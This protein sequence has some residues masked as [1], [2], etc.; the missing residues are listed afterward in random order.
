[1]NTKYDFS[2]RIQHFNGECE[3]IILVFPRLKLQTTVEF[4]QC[5]YFCF[6]VSCKF[7]MICEPNFNLPQTINIDALRKSEE[8]TNSYDQQT[9]KTVDAVKHKISYIQSQYKVLPKFYDQFYHLNSILSLRS[10]EYLSCRWNQFLNNV[11]GEYVRIRLYTE[12]TKG[13]E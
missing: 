12:Y 11:P 8:S 7:T 2:L 9:H 10:N 13:K 1:M 4:I 3:I 5:F 6:P